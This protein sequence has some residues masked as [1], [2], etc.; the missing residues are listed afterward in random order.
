MKERNKKMIPFSIIIPVYNIEPYLEKCL[1]SVLM[2]SFR[3]FELILVNDGS[4]DGSLQICQQ[5]AR[6]DKRIRLI[7]QPNQGLSKARNA[8]IQQAS[9]EY[10]LFLDGDDFWLSE[11]V[12]QKIQDCLNEARPDVLSFNFRKVTGDEYGKPYFT[13]SQI[14]APGYENKKIPVNWIACAWNK[15]VRRK[16]F[17]DHDLFFHA[18]ITSE[19]IDWC[20]RL[21]LAAE[22]FGYLPDCI[23]GYVQRSG[24]ISANMDEKKVIQLLKNIEEAAA[25]LE[26]GKASDDRRRALKGYLGY[27]TATLMV[28]L[29]F[30][31][32]RIFRKKICQ[33]VRP[34]I[35]FLRHHDLIT[36]RAIALCSEIAG[37]VLTVELLGGYYR[38]RQLFLRYRSV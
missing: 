16:L 18:G 15:V 3:G 14:D 37:P 25:L 13:Q 21:A 20:M 10:I 17:S 27:Q 7:S 24:S 8:G 2:Q 35:P 32:N 28:N 38:I 33:S 4:Q 23:V 29:S 19:D 30:I 5:Y 36:M 11:I 26:K 31:Q 34:L 12:L 22:T 6:L 1:N 9:G